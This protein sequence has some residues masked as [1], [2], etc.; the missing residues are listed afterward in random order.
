MAA[1]GGGDSRGGR[2]EK[3]FFVAAKDEYFEVL[4]G[5]QKRPAEKA[6]RS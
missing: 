2:G 5:I 1:A 6:G 3:Q 4:R